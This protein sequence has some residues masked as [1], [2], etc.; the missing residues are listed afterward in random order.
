MHFKKSILQDVYHFWLHCITLFLPFT[1]RNCKGNPYCLNGLGEK[2]WFEELDESNWH[3]FDPE[4]ERRPEVI[5]FKLKC[6]CLNKIVFLCILWNT[7]LK[8]AFCFICF[9]I[10]QIF[11]YTEQQHVRWKIIFY[12][13]MTFVLFYFIAFV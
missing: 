1:R 10:I 12:S 3:D 7:L 2:K 4:S 9:F 11:F 5:L 6:M 8:Y 13:S